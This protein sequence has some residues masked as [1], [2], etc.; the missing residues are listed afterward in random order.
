MAYCP[1]LSQNPMSGIGAVARSNST[2]S[3][4]SPFSAAMKSGAVRPRPSGLIHFGALVAEALRL[5][6]LIALAERLDATAANWKRIPEQIRVAR[7]AGQ[8]LIVK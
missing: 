5:C 7:T 6:N 2:V 4:E 1:C 8:N 3:L